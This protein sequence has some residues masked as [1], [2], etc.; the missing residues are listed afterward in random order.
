[1]THSDQ[2]KFS[3]GARPVEFHQAGA[4]PDSEPRLVEAGDE[5]VRLLSKNLRM[6]GRLEDATP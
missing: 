5:K 6:P 3:Y 1:M 4:V 2:N